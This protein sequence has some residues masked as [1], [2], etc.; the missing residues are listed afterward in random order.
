MLS[1]A[2][3]GT[4]FDLGANVGFV[5]SGYF[6]SNL[7]VIIIY[8][9]ANPKIIEL[10]R[11]SIEYHSNSSVELTHACITSEER[12]LQILSCK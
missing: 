5:P 2:D 3:G 4:F 1:T 11:H 10:L 6:R 12:Y 7:Y 8:S 9:E